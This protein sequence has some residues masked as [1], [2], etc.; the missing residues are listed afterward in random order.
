MAVL[1][2]LPIGKGANFVHAT[3][4]PLFDFQ[5]VARE[6]TLVLFASRAFSI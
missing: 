2:P 3:L 5:K 6:H 4:S 1:Q